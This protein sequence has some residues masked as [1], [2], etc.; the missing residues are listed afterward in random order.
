MS[1]LIDSGPDAILLYPEVETTDSDGNIVRR[2]SKV[3]ITV[4]AQLHRLKADEIDSLGIPSTSLFFNTSTP[5][6]LGSYAKAETRGRSWDVVGE[7]IRTGRSERTAHTRVVLA[8][9]QARA[10]SS[11]G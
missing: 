4:N 5:L 9:R 1:R 10:V 11:G 7:P 8:A 3:P 6:P 2:P